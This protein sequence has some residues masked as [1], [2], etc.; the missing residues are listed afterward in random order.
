MVLEGVHRF[1]HADQG[2][3]HEALGHWRAKALGG[4]RE[5]DAR[6]R[7]LAAEK[8]S[9]HA[10]LTIPAKSAPPNCQAFASRASKVLPQHEPG[11]KGECAHALL[12]GLLRHHGELKASLTRFR[13]SQGARL[14]ALSLRRCSALANVPRCR[15]PFLCTDPS[16]CCL[17]LAVAACAYMSSWAGLMHL[18]GF[19][20]AQCGSGG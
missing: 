19:C 20:C 6:N 9:A 11:W 17:L 5:W 4:A 15:I 12:V 14:K 1:G 16:A 10:L 2:E 13:A 18:C 3:L 8:A 7:A